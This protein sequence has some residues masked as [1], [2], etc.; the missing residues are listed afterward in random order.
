MRTS[1]KS[2]IPFFLITILILVSLACGSSSTVSPT[3]PVGA[4]SSSNQAQ[5]TNQPQAT[6]PPQATNTPKPTQVPPT[7]TAVPIG[8][9]R[10]NPY[11]KTELVNAP[12]W[13]YPSLEMNL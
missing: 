4:T 10:S 2:T 7:P 6:V 12:N 13:D 9:S 8:L 11:P 1:S 3:L 5:S